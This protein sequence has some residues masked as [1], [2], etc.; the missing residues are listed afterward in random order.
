MIRLFIPTIG[1][2]LVLAKDWSF[3]LHEE[4]RNFQFSEFFQLG[5]NRVWETHAHFGEI[6]LPAGTV[7]KIDR[8]YIRKGGADMKEFD[9][10]TFFCN[11]HLTAAQAKKQKLPKGRFWAKLQDV[12]QMMIKEIA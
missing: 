5:F 1:T 3:V 8:I 7:L 12:N 11:P 10:V 6:S 2:A 4:Y 9:S